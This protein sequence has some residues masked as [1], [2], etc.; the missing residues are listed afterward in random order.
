[1]P[2]LDVTIKNIGNEVFEQFI[3]EWRW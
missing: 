1:V 2:T 3:A